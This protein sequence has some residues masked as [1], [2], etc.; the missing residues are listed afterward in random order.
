MSACAIAELYFFVC[1]FLKE[2]S[3][4]KVIKPL[5]LAC[6]EGM[7]SKCKVEEV[8]KRACRSIYVSQA[9]ASQ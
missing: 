9:M 5:K 7:S 1:V 2:V 6:T 4:L 3:D 8:M